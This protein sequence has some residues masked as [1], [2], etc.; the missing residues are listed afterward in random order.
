MDRNEKIDLLNDFIAN[1]KES[2]AFR[3][4]AEQK[5]IEKIRFAI[6]LCRVPIL[7]YLAH[8]IGDPDEKFELLQEIEQGVRKCKTDDELTAF[9]GEFEQKHK[10]EIE[11]YV[12]KE[13]EY[14]QN[15]IYHK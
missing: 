1:G 12:Q 3:Q 8:K 11:S 4:L 6:G 7:K 9:M 5:L 15:K 14:W 13:E 2:N 10:E